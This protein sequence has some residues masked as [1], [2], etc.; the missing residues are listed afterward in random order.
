MHK[1]LLQEVDHLHLSDDGDGASKL[2]M[3]HK[4]KDSHHSSTSIVQLNGTLLKLGLLVE[5]VPSTPESSVTKI[6]REFVSESIHV[7]HDGNLQQTNE[8]ED[9]DSSLDRDGISTV[10]GGPAVGV[11]VEGMSGRVDVS[12]EV[13][14]GAGEDVTQEGKLGNTSVLDLN[15]TE[16][17]ES[18][19]VGLVQKS[20]G[21]E[22]SDR[23][24]GT[25]LSLEGIEGGGGLAGHSRGKGGGRGGKGG[26]DSKLHHG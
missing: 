8:G 20:K 3:H 14:S 6:S 22:E 25:K 2:L 16:A 5:L 24:L 7:L 26:E 21:I 12:S 9:L 15:V 10:D 11:G 23:G 13:S 17:V 19:L 18:L 1:E 4:S